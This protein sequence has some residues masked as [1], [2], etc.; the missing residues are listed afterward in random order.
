MNRRNRIVKAKHTKESAMSPK[1]IDSHEI[2]SNRSI[3]KVL[4]SI[5]QNLTG[6]NTSQRTPKLKGKV[7][8]DDHS[9]IPSKLFTR[10]MTNHDEEL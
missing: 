8:S 4:K 2:T 7:P 3:S 6:D 9:Q 10:K 5:D 1:A